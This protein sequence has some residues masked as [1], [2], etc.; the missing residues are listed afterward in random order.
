MITLYIIK[1][2]NIL[3]SLFKKIYFK[4]YISICTLRNNYLNT[5]V[6]SI[7]PKH[8]TMFVAISVSTFSSR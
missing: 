8:C 4:D 2:Q 7:A 6:S 1:I 5:T 3:G